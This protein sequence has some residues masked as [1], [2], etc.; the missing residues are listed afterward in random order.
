[1]ENTGSNGSRLSWLVLSGDASAVLGLPPPRRLAEDFRQIRETLQIV[2]APE[3]VH[4]GHDGARTLRARLEAL[5]AEQGIEPDQPPAGFVQ[6]FHF[7]R[8][9][10]RAVAVEAITDE[11]HDG[12]LA[13]NPA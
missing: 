7:L 9:P 5:I 11:Q 1:M 3:I 4:M 13:E 12:A 10:L 6:S 2:H 8:Q